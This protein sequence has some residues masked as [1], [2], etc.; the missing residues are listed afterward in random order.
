VLTKDKILGTQEIKWRMVESQKLTKF[1][2]SPEINISA[3]WSVIMLDRWVNLSLKLRWKV[4][5]SETIHEEATE[6]LQETE[7]K[8]HS[9]LQEVADKVLED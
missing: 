1:N 6:D 7:A 2:L 9:K 8:E 5:E 4:P 3:I